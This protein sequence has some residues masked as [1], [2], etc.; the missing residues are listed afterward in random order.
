[1]WGLRKK[2]E[3]GCY[4]KTKALKAQETNEMELQLL[5]LQGWDLRKVQVKTNKQTNSQGRSARLQELGDGGSVRSR[6][7]RHG[8]R[9]RNTLIDQPACCG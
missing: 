6:W 4:R 8:E 2:R 1:V 3:G 9:L 5:H 7:R